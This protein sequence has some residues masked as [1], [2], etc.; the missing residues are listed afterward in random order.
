MNIF[1]FVTALM[2]AGENAQ[3]ERG[4]ELAQQPQWEIR[5]MPHPSTGEIH[6]YHFASPNLSD[7]DWWRLFAERRKLM[8]GQNYRLFNYRAPS[9]VKGWPDPRPFL[10][11]KIPIEPGPTS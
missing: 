4:F 1:D 5:R 10:Q 2:Q 3:T 7:E 11:F 8:E 6:E 9:H